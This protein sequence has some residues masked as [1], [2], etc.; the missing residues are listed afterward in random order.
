MYVQ[1]IYTQTTATTGAYPALRFIVVRF[2][3]DS[4][5]QTGQVRLQ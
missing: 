5:K 3:E 2:G 4:A 1:P